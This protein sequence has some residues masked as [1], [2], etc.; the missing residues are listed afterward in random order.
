M[1]P[2]SNGLKLVMSYNIRPN[3]AQAYYQF[4]LGHYIPQMQSMGL[5]MAEA[6]HTAYGDYPSRLI[7]F[8]SQDEYTIRQVVN[9]AAWDELN[10]RLLQFVTDFDYKVIPYRIGFQF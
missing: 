1:D 5:E 9:D 6:W 7:V 3:D 8:V 4:V 2:I 10:D